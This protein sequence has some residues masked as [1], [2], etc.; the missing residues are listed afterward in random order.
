MPSDV[1]Q[2]ERDRFRE[3]SN[4]S[5]VAS[6]SHATYVVRPTN[7][8]KEESCQLISTWIENEDANEWINQ[9]D[10]QGKKRRTRSS[11]I[12]P[13]VVFVERTIEKANLPWT[14]SWP[15]FCYLPLLW[16]HQRAPFRLARLYLVSVEEAFSEEMMRRKSKF[17]SHGKQ[18]TKAWSF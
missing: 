7:C 15:L 12:A 5:R 18:R 10:D 3:V 13:I 4:V 2:D 17:G 11:Q 9:T 14:V 1:R 8:P 6:T 16:Q